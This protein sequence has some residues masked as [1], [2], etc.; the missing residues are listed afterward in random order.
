MPHQPQMQYT[1]CPSE[2]PRGRSRRARPFVAPL[3][4]VGRILATN[5]G[6]RAFGMARDD[7]KLRGIGHGLLGATP[8]KAGPIFA[9]NFGYKAFGMARDDKKS[10]V[11]SGPI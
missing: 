8:W 6:C 10:E 1:H 11:F 2:D 4:K 7:Q 9:A 3:R 5:F